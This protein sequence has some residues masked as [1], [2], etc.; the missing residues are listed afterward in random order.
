VLGTPCVDEVADADADVAVIVVPPSIVLDAIEACGEA[1]VR[2][3]V[4][5]TAG[6]GET[7]EDD[8]AARERR[9]AEIADEYDLNLVGPNSLGI[10]S[11][12]SGMNATFGPENAP[13][14]GSPL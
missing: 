7:G 10:M 2:N 13:R 11:T 8:G 1:G 4:V 12:P 3:V 5:I 9:L 14:A 6:F